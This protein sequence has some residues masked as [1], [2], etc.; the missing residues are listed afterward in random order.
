MN[1]GVAAANVDAPS[2]WFSDSRSKSTGTN[3]RCS[4]SDSLA[5]E[6]AEFRAFPL[7]RCGMVDLEYRHRAAR[8]AQRKRIEPGS[9]N[10]ILTDAAPARALQRIFGIARADHDL[11]THLR[12]AAATLAIDAPP[13]L[14]QRVE[15]RQ[16]S[17]RVRGQ[18]RLDGRI[19]EDRRCIVDVP[20]HCTQNRGG[21]RGATGASCLHEPPPIVANAPQRSRWDHVTRP[22]FAQHP[23]AST[24]S[25]PRAPI[26]T[27]AGCSARVR[28]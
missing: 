26:G 9:E 4:G 27:R 16:E 19:V 18:Q 10:Q 21:L 23:V 3:S 6:R 14:R 25:L 11:C 8:I 20:M 7:L 1:A 17:P 22:R 12:E 24:H 5:R 15:A 28:D 13:R 2:A